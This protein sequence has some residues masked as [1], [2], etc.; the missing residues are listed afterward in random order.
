MSHSQ[1]NKII[2]E[3][4]VILLEALVIICMFELGVG[5][6]AEPI[7]KHNHYVEFDEE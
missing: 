4:Y 1:N 3:H 5:H 6:L 7:G 2:G